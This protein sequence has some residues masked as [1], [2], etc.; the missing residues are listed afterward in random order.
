MSSPDPYALDDKLN[1]LA[2]LIADQLREMCEGRKFN[3]LLIVEQKISD[4]PEN[5]ALCEMIGTLGGKGILRMMET[6]TVAVKA[7]LA[8]QEAKN[9]NH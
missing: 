6:A 9:G 4:D 7:G 5:N 1:D 8:E 3:M 2:K